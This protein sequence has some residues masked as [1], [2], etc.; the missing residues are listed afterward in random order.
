MVYRFSS[1]YF[2]FVFGVYRL[3][4][5]VFIQRKSQGNVQNHFH[6]QGFEYQSMPD[7]TQNV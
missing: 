7:N 3:N 5:F 6:F 2:I 4:R 1:V